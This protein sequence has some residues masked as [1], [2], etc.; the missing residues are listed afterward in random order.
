[1]MEKVQKPSNSVCFEEVHMYRDQC[2]IRTIFENNTLLAVH[3][4]TPGWK[5]F[6]NRWHSVSIAFPVNVAK[7]TLVKE[8]D[9]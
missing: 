8:A 5:E 3:S 4:R 9:F 7:G 6:C 2:E 1:M